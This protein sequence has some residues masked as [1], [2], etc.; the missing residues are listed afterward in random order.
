MR[1]YN[2]PN[3]YFHFFPIKYILCA[4]KTLFFAQNICF[5]GQL[6]EKSINRPDSLNPLC[7]KFLIQISEYLEQSKFKFLKSY[8]I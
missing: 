3:E 1:V 4:K 2:C 6:I 8:C 5:Y 7:L